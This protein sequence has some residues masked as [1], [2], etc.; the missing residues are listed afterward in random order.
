MKRSVVFL[1]IAMLT[2]ILNGCIISVAPKDDPV[3]VKPGEVKTF[4]FHVFP[5]WA[6][7]EWSVDGMPITTAS[8]GTFKYT[9]NDAVASEHTIDVKATHNFGTEVYRWNINSLRITNISP[10]A[11][12]P[13]NTVTISYIGG[14]DGVPLN[15]TLG[16]VTIPVLSQQGSSNT[17]MFVV[18]FGATSGPILL[19]DG[20]RKS[21]SVYLYV[22]DIS[23]VTPPKED[24]VL[25]E[26]GN[27]VSV[28]LV[29]VSMKP[30]F[31]TREEAQKVADLQGGVIV[32]RIPMINAYQI[33]LQT[34]TL[35]ELRDAIAVMKTALT[36]DFVLEDQKIISCAAN[37]DPE[38]NFEGQRGSNKVEEGAAI[39]S[40]YV[41]P[42]DPNKITP[43]KVVIGI[44]D[45]SGLDG[46]LADFDQTE[47][48]IPGYNEISLN[49][50]Y[51][52]GS[53]HTSLVAGMMV[54]DLGDGTKSGGE[55]S[56]LLS[57]L[58]D[59]QG[60]P[61]HGGFEIIVARFE[62]YKEESQKAWLGDELASANRFIDISKVTVLNW[63]W[64]LTMEGSIK[65]DGTINSQI[66]KTAKG[67][68]T[69]QEFEE[70]KKAYIKL[71][72]DLEEN[73]KNVVVVNAAGNE[74]TE[75]SNQLP[76]GISSSSLI[77]VA[78]HDYLSTGD[79]FQR[80]SNSNFG[81]T[82]DITAAWTVQG[83]KG[84]SE[85]GTSVAAP[86][87]SATVAA[88][89]SIN[90]NITA[91]QLKQL[92]RT[93]A[94]P[95]YNNIVYT[96]TGT[97]VFTRA[98]TDEE[99]G[100]NPSRVGQGAILNVQG[101]INEA[102]KS[103]D[104]DS[105]GLPDYIELQ[106]DT[107]PNDADTDDDGLLDGEE[108]ANHNGVVDAGETDPRNVDTDGDG[109][110]D[111]TELGK[112]Q[113]PTHPDTS[114]FIFQPD[115]DPTTT[116]NPLDPDTDH[117]G[118]SD[119]VE[120][121]NHNGRVD[122]GESNP[123]IINQPPV[124]N[125]GP[126]Q[127]V[128]LGANVTLDG[129]GST[130][131][132]NNIASYHWQQTGGPTVTLTNPDVAIAQ[133]T[134]AVAAGSTLTFDLTVTDA[135]GLTSTPDTCVVLVQQPAYIPFV[136]I[137]NSSYD[138]Q[139]P[140]IA[141]T[142]TGVSYVVWQENVNGNWEIFLSRVDNN[143]TI[144]QTF[145]KINISSTTGASRYPDIAVDTSNRCYI[146]WQEGS[147]INFSIV[148]QN[149]VKVIDKKVID[150]GSC[151]NPCISAAPNGTCNIVYENTVITTFYVYYSQVNSAGTTLVNK[152]IV[153]NMDII[154]ILPKCPF[155][156]TAADGSSYILWR[157][158][159]NWIYGI[160]Y[161]S[162]SSSGT[163][164][165]ASRFITDENATKPKMGLSTNNGYIALQYKEGSIQGVYTYYNQLIQ[166]DQSSYD[167]TNPTIAS[168]N[169]DN[170]YIAWQD[171]RNGIW[172]IY[173]AQL[174]IDRHRVGD[175]IRLTD[176]ISSSQEPDISVIN[177]ILYLVWQNN[178]SGL[179]QII[180]TRKSS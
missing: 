49:T 48:N 177:G 60:N 121:A 15:V 154:G 104:S 94:T 96:T 91:Q 95:I 114:L 26:I 149:G 58:K 36:V 21:N 101:A 39:Y 109:L 51:D 146:V 115:L 141:T 143:G 83:S 20:H 103:L 19:T 87:V 180:F 1:L 86:L 2:A 144:D 68:C 157:D 168:D 128:A 130:D 34:H 89:Q 73:H 102:L 74:N 123:N 72:K 160:Y 8:K 17:G 10:S 81:N 55:M 40:Q 79:Y 106:F 90:P 6:K 75:V 24:V 156:I 127:T 161:R 170:A 92:L 159:T 32:G 12:L 33:H 88:M 126:D 113:Y 151:S 132:D 99:S 56:G 111:G 57:A 14:I 124:A 112:A 175:E 35:Q 155:I 147:A 165:S 23:V 37:W 125:A 148:D 66:N 22:S 44:Y 61:L 107:N 64:G 53:G 97:V 171:M 69:P 76:A 31:D 134:A 138:C 70:L 25:D 80:N 119:G 174:G 18:P 176:S 133:F 108:D 47:T 158:F 163:L 62:D 105:D 98:L 30:E 135:G 38:N 65:A 11:V 172:D 50:V 150:S 77:V 28:N 52:K 13:G 93:G 84:E 145:G 42:S 29:L 78:G 117:D 167:A 122:P 110:Q 118:I 9:S 120:D 100:G 7:Y 169:T 179:N 43:H 5:F 152:R 45:D 136:A 131:P 178:A 27:E 46:T 162:V 59:D 16:D 173:I 166:V 137:S 67:T 129:S 71:F 4:K 139:F 63:S 164:G 153:A 142:A 82:V 3:I 54:A 140:A 85:E 116:T 41:N